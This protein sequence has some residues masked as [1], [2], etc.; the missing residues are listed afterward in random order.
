MGDHAAIA[1]VALGATVIEKHFTLDRNLPGPAH[2]ASLEPSELTAMIQKLHETSLALGDGEKQPGPDEAKTARLVRRSWH[3]ARDLVA[4]HVLGERDI[5]LKR[6]DDGL[7][8]GVCLVGRKLTVARPADA[9]ITH[10]DI[11]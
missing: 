11:A 1:A 7:A 3:A 6:P 10:A 9:P 8:P 4:G 2:A 5:V